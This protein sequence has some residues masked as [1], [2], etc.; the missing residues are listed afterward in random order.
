MKND[1]ERELSVLIVDDERLARE[2]LRGLLKKHWNVRIA[3]EA[4]NADEAEE[5]IRE[6]QPDLV[7]LDIQM[8]GG[9]GFDL[10]ER[11]EDPPFIVFVTA[12][13]RFAIRAFEVNALDYLLKPVDPERLK[14]ALGRITY[15][16]KK[17]VS[18]ASLFYSSDRVFLK[19]GKKVQFVS[20]L[21]IAAIVAEK[22]YTHVMT[23]KG[24]R[25]IVHFP[26]H[27]WERRL[28]KDIFVVLDRSLM[29][30]RNHIQSWKTGSRNAELS[31]TGIRTPFYLGRSAYQRFKAMNKYNQQ[32][33]GD[34]ED[35]QTRYI[36]P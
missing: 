22:N 8:P 30:N 12:Y 34:S 25:Y 13:D 27:Y 16:T 23:I 29:I 32:K 1:P 10:L 19:T 3:G 21:D 7:F 14:G 24:K 20:L 5:M 28:P 35:Q 2:K 9:S 31:L 17:Q 6:A 18:N 11:L 4:R 26:F 36:A 15:R 33:G